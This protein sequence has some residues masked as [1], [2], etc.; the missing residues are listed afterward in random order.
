MEGVKGLETQRTCPQK[1]S[2]FSEDTFFLWLRIINLN[3]S[4]ACW[5]KMGLTESSFQEYSGWGVFL[6]EKQQT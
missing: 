1:I 5:R 6:S 2:K 3:A 4:N